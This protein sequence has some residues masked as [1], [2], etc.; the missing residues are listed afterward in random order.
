M[1]KYIIF[2][3]PFFAYSLSQ[4]QNF[5][6][7]P[8]PISIEVDLNTTAN[9][10]EIIGE[11]IITNNTS[12]TLKLKWERIVN[13][14]PDC[15]ET[16]VFGV[17]IQSLPHID[18]L[19]FD[20][21]SNNDELLNISVF[22]GL[23]G[24]DPTT[25][26]AEVVLKITNLYD[27][28]DTLLVEFNFLITGD[29]NCITGVSEIEYES[30]EVYPNPVNEN[31]IFESEVIEIE[32]VNIYDLFGNVIMNNSCNSK[33]CKLSTSKLDNGVYIAE[34]KT[35]TKTLIRKIIKK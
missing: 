29:N 7:T 23:M 4:A 15:W 35:R 17:W 18:S 3:L 9:P 11:S 13:D 12:D 32:S 1:L 34:I 30:L 21:N 8:N 26:E 19:E 20:L 25:G 2:F 27:S 6:V 10:Y 14:K 31:I 5:T 16:S 24:N 28:T 22:T 33:R